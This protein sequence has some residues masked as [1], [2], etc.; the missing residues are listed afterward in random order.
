[1]KI[2][3]PVIFIVGFI[4]GSMLILQGYSQAPDHMTFFGAM[5]A[6]ITLGVVFGKLFLAVSELG[7]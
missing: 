3:R 4:P 2:P 5:G 6:A 7:G 1:M